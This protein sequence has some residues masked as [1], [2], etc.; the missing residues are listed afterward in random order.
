MAEHADSDQNE[1]SGI[2]V[3]SATNH[4]IGNHVSG[5][6]NAFF[7]NHQGGRTYGIGAANGRTCIASSPFGTKRAKARG[8]TAAGAAK[9]ANGADGAPVASVYGAGVVPQ[10]QDSCSA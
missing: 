7:A 3:L 4:L 6:D 9:P 2:Y 8:A 5:H 1:Q 10:P